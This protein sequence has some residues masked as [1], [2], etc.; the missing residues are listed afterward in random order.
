MHGPLGDRREERVRSIKRYSSSSVLTFHVDASMH[1][2]SWFAGKHTVVAERIE[3]ARAETHAN[4]GPR[5]NAGNTDFL[6]A[7]IFP[8]EEVGCSSGS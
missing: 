8:A 1:G 2:A 7:G 3:G 4:R 5:R 6:C